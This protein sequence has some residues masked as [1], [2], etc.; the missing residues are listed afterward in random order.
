MFEKDRLR[1]KV[2]NKLKKQDFFVLS[3]LGILSLSLSLFIHASL[4]L[5]AIR[6][7]G[8]G[9]FAYLSSVFI[10]HDFS[11]TSAFNS[12]AVGV[13]AQQAYG[14]GMHPETGKMFI[15]YLPG[16]A[17][18]AAPFYLLADITSFCLGWPRTGDSTPYQIAAIVAVNFYL[19]V[20]I[21]AIFKTAR[22]DHD[23]VISTLV[24]SLLVFAT[25]VYHYAVY[26]V[27]MAHIYSFAIVAIYVR[28]LMLY[29]N[30]CRPYSVGFALRLGVLVGLIALIRATDAIVVLLAAIVVLHRPENVKNIQ[31]LLVRIGA[32]VCAGLATI[33]PLLAYWRFSTGS[34]ITNSYKV[35]SV[36]GVTLEGFNWSRPELTNFLFSV[37]RGF[38]F[39]APITLLGFIGLIPMIQK[40]KTWGGLVLL[41]LMTHVYA[42]S[43]WWVWHFGLSFGSRPMVDVMPLIALPLSFILVKLNKVVR[44]PYLI[45]IALLFIALNALLMLSFWKGAVPSH[46]T[47]LTHLQQLPHRL[48]SDFLVNRNVASNVDLDIEGKIIG[49]KLDISVNLTNESTAR[50]ESFSSK[51]ETKVGLRFVPIATKVGPPPEVPWH[52]RDNLL[53]SLAPGASILKRFE[54]DIPSGKDDFLFEVTLVQEGVSW[55]HMIGMQKARLLIVD[56]KIVKPPRVLKTELL[57]DKDIATAITLN[58]VA[59]DA[60]DF[61]KVRLAITNTSDRLFSTASRKLP[62]NVVWRVLPASQIDSVS[63]TDLWR[64]IEDADFSL[65]PR[66]TY[67]DTFYFSLPKLSGEYVFEAS[68]VQHQNAWFHHLG[69]KVPQVSVVVP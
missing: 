36:D 29:R 45:F 49:N 44:Q 34:F 55:F 17:I 50:F 48:F 41:T 1:P 20:G 26:D 56:D 61:L 13:N 8:F 38:F 68:L 69:M 46:G 39:W 51:G 35:F 15:K 4:A 58:A 22:L 47:T 63:S 62:I 7:D 18:L 14:L 19:L 24:T 40:N 32:F 31:Q 21:W 3:V 57:V 10:D 6:S 30:K 52:T 67:T 5:P 11:F 25:N 60:G 9:Y 59:E 16:V 33:S 66:E 27:S 23:V 28:E 43:S 42:C 64:S 2:K 37:D 12:I 65:A 54:L 53:I